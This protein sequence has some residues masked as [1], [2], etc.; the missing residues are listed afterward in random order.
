M[1]A[2]VPAEAPA[3]FDARGALLG[4]LVMAGFGIG[5]TAW[6]AGVLGRGAAT[7]LQ[8]A[9]LGVGLLL[10]IAAVRRLRQSPPGSGISMVG[11]RSYW[12]LVAAEAVAIAAGLAILGA[13]GA[14]RYS[15]AWVATVVGVHFLAFGRLFWRGFLLV[16]ASLLAGSALALGLGLAG[17]GDSVVVAVAALAAAAVLFV[18]AAFGIEAAGRAVAGAASC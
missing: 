16:G 14:S 15:A 11:T 3:G 12:T 5:W 10:I 4:A 2:P 17:A 7:A 8:I 9:G 13:M 6:G 18:T 1:S